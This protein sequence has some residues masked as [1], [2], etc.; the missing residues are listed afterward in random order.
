MR[1]R[2]KKIK[3]K[4]YDFLV[5]RNKHVMLEYE[6]YVNDH[7][8]EH[9]KNRFR[10]WIILIKLKWHYE[11]RKERK[12]MIYLDQI[13]KGNIIDLLD[14][15]AST[16][17][18][19]AEESKVF[20]YL[21]NFR[22]LSVN[23]F[24]ATIIDYDVI[25]FDVFDTLIFRKIEKP[26]DIFNIM[27]AE[28]GMN[29]F[30][31]IRKTAETY[32]RDL[33][34]MDCGSREV[35]LGEIYDVLSER[36]DVDRK[37]MDREIELEIELSVQNPYI[38]SV[39]DVL[40]GFRKKIVFMTDMYLP[41]DVIKRILEKNGYTQYDQIILSNEYD[42]RKGDG[43]LQKILLEKYPK[44]SVI[45]LGDNY[46]SDVEKSVKVGLDAGYIPDGG[47]TFRE[48]W[49]D[50]LAGSF[51]RGVIQTNM[52]T[53]CW[54]KDIYYSHGYRTG[55]LLAAG[56][57]DFINKIVS[58]KRIDKILF[59][60]RDC[61][62]IYKIY[63]RFYKKTDA[64]YVNI[65]RY[66]VFNITS[67]HYLYDLAGRFILR[68][69]KM[70]S[71]LKTISEILEE[72]G[73][74]YL[75]DELDKN[76]IDR[77]SF[78]S[79]IDEKRI[80]EFIYSCS[81]LIY[82]HNKTARE[83]ARKYFGDVVGSAKNVLVVDIGWSGTCI[84]ALKYFVEKNLSDINCTISGALMCSNRNDVVKNSV[85]FEDI[86][87]YINSPFDN[88]DT[89]RYI[90]PGPPQSR[91]AVAMDMLHMPLEYLFTSLES[92]L[93]GYD[94]DENGNVIF[95]YSDKTANNPEQIKSMQC[96]IMDFVEAYNECSALCTRDFRIPPYTAFAPLKEA[97]NHS[98]YSY[99]VY[100][101]FLYDAMSCANSSERIPLYG[102]LFGNKFGSVKSSADDKNAVKTILFV[103]PEMIYT[104]APRSLL[105][106]CKVASYLGYRVK[107]WSAK[108]GSFISEF[109]K[110]NFTVEIVPDNTLNDHISEIKSFDMAV[111][112]TIVTSKYAA[113]CC[114]YIPTVWYIREATN[115]P[116]FIR[117]DPE[118]AYILKNSRDIYVVSDYA[119]RALEIYADHPVSVV[120][121]CVEDETDMALPYIPGTGEKIKFVQF[122]TIE[123]RKGYDVLLAAYKAM[124]E[125]YRNASELYFAGG[126]INSGTPFASYLFGKTEGVSGVHY[127]GVVKGEQKKI[128]TLSGMDVV[129]VASRDESCSLVALEGAML[130]KPLIVTQNV[131]AKYM[132]SENNGFIVETGNVES[133]SNAM[134]KLIDMKADLAEMGKSS[135][136]M[137]EKYA[138][139]KSYIGNMSTLYSLVDMKHTKEFEKI[140]ENNRK[141]FS[142][143][144]IRDGI[145]SQA[146]SRA[147]KELDDKAIVSLTS[148]PGRIGIVKKCIE[149][150]MVQTV[151][152]KKIIL[153]LSIEQFPN[154]HGSLPNEL[155]ALENMGGFFEIRF[156]KGDL[157]PHKKY[158][159]AMQEFPD[160]PII[161]VDDDVYYD[162]HL[163][164][165]LLESYTKFP[166]CVSAMRVNLIG[167]HKTGKIMDYDGWKMGYRMLADTPSTQLIP[168][169]VGGVLYP[170]HILPKETFDEKAIEET[171]LFCD[172][173]WLKIMAAHANIKTVFPQKSCQETLIEDSQDCALWKMNVRYGNNNDMCMKNIMEYYG[174]NIGDTEKLLD[175]LRKDRFC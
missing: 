155:T 32:A 127:L 53:G 85:Q 135:R 26:N 142:V 163:V 25:S 129:V 56:F 70:Y 122:G 95:N 73:Y 117:N 27:S 149:T 121:N 2:I 28:M 18:M 140:A 69:I 86:V 57:C 58:D 96:G 54:D 41:L 97:M 31:S 139:M 98:R 161:I 77:Y 147:N 44:Q 29:D 173:L 62:I 74:G 116:D 3:E 132:V 120:N 59:C 115:I 105:R 49:L 165:Y 83:A 51:Y 162:K 21:N 52:N 66:A 146:S 6:R 87:S 166:D 47:F 106:M 134:M 138:S 152:P 5:R 158:F 23:K 125:N 61:D 13:I 167:F 79:S 172:D 72:T 36:F 9:N 37:W 108:N 1:E 88:I 145:R 90:F 30:I 113:L 171:C 159:Y 63:N 130:S 168:T 136:V 50:G 119:A 12:G 35:V 71:S 128:E 102:E 91:D 64:E 48:A 42:A 67:E 89:T 4:L 82:D 109:N 55:G 124:P 133:L 80:R 15:D 39:I 17:K 43:T 46:A 24:V 8:Y 60:S 11:I 175:W 157:K 100:K 7:K 93:L 150:L 92:T 14:R 107:V 174:K 94:F 38:H 112:N 164:E 151:T 103:S 123:Y 20:Y 141:V 84:T 99:E 118:R 19:I 114:Q 110:N 40:L 126:F 101:D 45:H 22:R 65:S 143:N 33:K 78:P 68:Y 153:W 154:K 81:K 170:P 111:C 76:N 131:G 137:Y 144:S 156:V 104:G 34:E 75:I 169:G 148:H 16:E 10:H 160:D